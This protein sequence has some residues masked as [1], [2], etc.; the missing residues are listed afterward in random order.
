LNGGGR[1][2]ERFF[3]GKWPYLGNGEMRPRLLLITNTKWHTPFQIRLNENHR[4]W[5]SL[6]VSDNQYGRLS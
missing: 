1:K 3:N 6:K 5:M 2:N 4:P